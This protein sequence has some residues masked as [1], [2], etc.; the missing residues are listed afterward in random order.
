MIDENPSIGIIL[1][2]NKNKNE[3]EIALQTATAPIGVADYDF[4][5]PDKKIKQIILDELKKQ[6]YLK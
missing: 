1:C 6:K 5:F 2:A 4:D 3:V